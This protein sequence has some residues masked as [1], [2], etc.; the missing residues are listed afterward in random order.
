MLPEIDLMNEPVVDCVIDDPTIDLRKLNNMVPD[1]ELED[2]VP[3]GLNALERWL[4]NHKYDG[5][6]DLDEYVDPEEEKAA[7]KEAKKRACCKW[8]YY[9]DVHTGELKRQWW[10]CKE[11]DCPH[12]QGQR[13]DESERRMLRALDYARGHNV[14]LRFVAMDSEDDAKKLVRKFGKEN[15][16]RSP[17]PDGTVEIYYVSD[18]DDDRW[19]GQVVSE[20]DIMERDWHDWSYV[21]DGKRQSGSLGIPERDEEVDDSYQTINVEEVVVEGISDEEIE[22]ANVEALVYHRGLDPKNAEEVERDLGFIMGTFKE[23]VIRR[24]GR[25]VLSTYKK[26]AVYRDKVNWKPAI[27]AA[28]LRSRGIDPP[29]V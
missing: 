17:N 29:T 28:I 10:T 13:A 20:E 14:E 25:I 22:E 21:P 5:I 12:C 27:K 2:V 1:S 3:E 9:R 6:V 24:G 8:V 11:K 4:W 7:H 18:D 19:N 26:K 16:Y 23:N 15:V